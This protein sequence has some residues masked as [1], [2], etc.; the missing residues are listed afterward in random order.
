MAKQ[1]KTSQTKT[2]N[3]TVITCIVSAMAAVLSLCY[4]IHKDYTKDLENINVKLAMLQSTVTANHEY[5]EK[6]E[7]FENEQNSMVRSKIS[8]IE[9]TQS[10]QEYRL[11]FLESK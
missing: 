3:I 11:R 8:A 1:T 5:I 4:L 2:S 9:S 7:A 10:D 6:N